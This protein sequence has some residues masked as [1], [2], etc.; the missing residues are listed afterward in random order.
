[1]NRDVGLSGRFCYVRMPIYASK[2]IHQFGRITNERV[3]S[4][5]TLVWFSFSVRLLSTLFSELP[6]GN[7]LRLTVGVST[8]RWC[9]LYR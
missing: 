4:S 5:Q 9:C 2:E 1:M 6:P 7:F 8:A 3:H